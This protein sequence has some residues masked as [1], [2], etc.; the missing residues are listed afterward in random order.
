LGLFFVS[1]SQVGALD[2]SSRKIKQPYR[3]KA[4]SVK[5]CRRG[6]WPLH[7]HFHYT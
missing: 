4:G 3:E 1:A 5:M 6:F 7:H 2:C